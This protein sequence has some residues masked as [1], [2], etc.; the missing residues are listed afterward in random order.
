MG[1]VWIYIIGL[2]NPHILASIDEFP[3]QHTILSF[4]KNS[5]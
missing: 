4:Q 1:K 2:D 5:P 3:F